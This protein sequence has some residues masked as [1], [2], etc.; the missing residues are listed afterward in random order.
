MPLGSV[1]LRAA[2]AAGTLAVCGLSGLAVALDTR[3]ADAPLTP[4]VAG[5]S[6][7][8]AGAAA[9]DLSIPAGA[10]C[11]HAGPSAAGGAAKA[12]PV[13]ADLRPLV[14]QYRAATTQQAR[15]QVLAQLTPD[16]RMQLTAYLQQVAR[17]RQPASRQ[18]AGGGLG[19]R[20]GATGAGGD[21]P[22]AGADIGPDVVAGTPGSPVSVSAVS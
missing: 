22:A 12:P 8:P 19:C 10:T 3:P 7:A 5:A 2:G 1:A 11:A 21:T 16:Q 14:A 20:G 17:S 18:G 13:P 6:P 9:G 4:A 15:Q